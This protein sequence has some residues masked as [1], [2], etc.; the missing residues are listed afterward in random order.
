MIA[1]VSQDDLTEILRSV[2]SGGPEAQ[3]RL[4]RAIYDELHRMAERFMRR[5]R[6]DHTLQPSA[7]VNEALL[8]LFDGETLAKAHDRRYLYAAAAQA[9]RQILV[10]HARRRN[11]AK[12]AGGWERVPLD[13]TLAYFE[14][15]C[16]DLIGLHDALDQLAA[17]HRRQGQVVTLRFFGGMSI[18]EV[19]AVLEVS[20]ATVESDWRLARA[21]LRTRLGSLD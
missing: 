19:A 10:E 2:P 8:R 4:I 13:E 18:P 12:R 14:D 3:E 21:W 15:R 17:I 20:E 11:A 7:L 1:H 16:L 5:E 9:M 6:P